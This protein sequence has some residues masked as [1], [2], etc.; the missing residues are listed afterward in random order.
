MSGCCRRGRADACRRAGISRSSRPPCSSSGAARRGAS[1]AARRGAGRR[2]RP[3]PRCSR[4]W[5]CARCRARCR[6]ADAAPT[7]PPRQRRCVARRPCLAHRRAALPARRGDGPHGADG[8]GG[9]RPLLPR[10]RCVR[11]GGAGGRRRGGLQLL[12]HWLGRRGR[13]LRRRLRRRAR[14]RKARW[15]AAR[16]RGLRPV[17]GESAAAQGD[18]LKVDRRSHR[19]HA[20]ALRGV[21]SAS[22]PNPYPNPYPIPNASPKPN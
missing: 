8:G 7:L 5:C 1:D 21:L 22:N 12:L 18:V 20:P 10:A 13:V 15:R 6:A 11:G 17:R 14:Q 2:T 3:R 19:G 9:A 16:A 4:A